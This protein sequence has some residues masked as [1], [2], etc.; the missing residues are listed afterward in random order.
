[1]AVKRPEKMK[2]GDASIA[3]LPCRIEPCPDSG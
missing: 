1:M 2:A 3:G